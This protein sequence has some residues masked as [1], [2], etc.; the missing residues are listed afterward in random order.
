MS[1]D[2]ETPEE[3]RITVIGPDG[4]AVAGGR[5]DDDENVTSPISSSNRPR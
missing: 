4:M 5:D 3:Q 1:E 2:A